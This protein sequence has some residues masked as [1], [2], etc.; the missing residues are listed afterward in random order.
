M[1]RNAAFFRYVALPAC[2]LWGVLEFFALQRAHLLRK[3]P[4]F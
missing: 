4:Y 3:R 2:I 1:T